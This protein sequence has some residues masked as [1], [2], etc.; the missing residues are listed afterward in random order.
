MRLR[1]EKR[2]KT[3]A[4]VL[5]T[6]VHKN[7]CEILQAAISENKDS[8]QPQ[9]KQ[10]LQYDTNADDAWQINQYHPLQ[11]RTLHSQ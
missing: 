11:T 10:E 3:K 9:F 1:P 6:A 8:A 4:T 7:T 5:T 2:G